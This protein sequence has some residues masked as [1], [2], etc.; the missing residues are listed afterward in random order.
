MGKESGTRSLD[1]HRFCMSL[2]RY[3]GDKVPIAEFFYLNNRHLHNLQ[4]ADTQTAIG[5][6][7]K[8]C[9]D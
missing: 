3:L 6:C 4:E 1:L 5:N 7:E 9:P 2:S 8:A